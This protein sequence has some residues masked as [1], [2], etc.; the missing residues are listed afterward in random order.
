MLDV[1]FNSVDCQFNYG[2]N[3]NTTDN[4]ITENVDYKEGLINGLWV[5][6]SWG[7]PLDNEVREN[8][9]CVAEGIPMELTSD[10][11]ASYYYCTSEPG[12][13]GLSFATVCLIIQN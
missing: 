8:R 9:L 3:V 10:S 12:D 11:L 7:V 13:C 5:L 6:A 1:F 2:S 4:P